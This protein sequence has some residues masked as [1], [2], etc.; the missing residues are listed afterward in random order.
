MI[1]TNQANEFPW[2]RPRYDVQQKVFITHTSNKF[3]LRH[4]TVQ[5]EIYGKILIL[6][7]EKWPNFCMN[8]TKYLR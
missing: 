7:A 2:E 8:Q 1:N 3:R 5:E 4:I 6:L